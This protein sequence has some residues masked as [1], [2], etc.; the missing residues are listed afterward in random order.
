MQLAPAERDVAKSGETQYKSGER[1]RSTALPFL[2]LALFLCSCSSPPDADTDLSILQGQLD[3]IYQLTPREVDEFISY[4]TAD[5]V[6]LPPD[7][8]AIEGK[9]AV[10]KFYES[11]NAAIESWK[12]DY[13][14]PVVDL[15]GDLAV[16]RYWGTNEIFFRD[17]AE[18]ITSTSRYLDVI[19]R[20]PDG[21]WKISVHSWGADD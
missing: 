10:F 18:S 16:R 15:S 19:R 17:R 21:S 7:F 12:L 1:M 3:E 8:P 9:E 13:S 4:F 2:I 20:Q 6:V 11:S 14:N 5:A